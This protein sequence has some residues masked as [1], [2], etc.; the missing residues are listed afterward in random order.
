[1]PAA[2]NAASI[3][4]R[5]EKCDSYVMIG[6]LASSLNVSRSGCRAKR[7]SGCGGLTTTT[8]SHSKTGIDFN[9]GVSASVSVAIPMSAWPAASMAAICGGFPCNSLTRT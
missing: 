5:P 6:Y 1:M 9:P 7:S 2:P 4:L 8:C 3:R